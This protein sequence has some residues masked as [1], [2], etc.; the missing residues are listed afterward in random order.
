MNNFV[1]I[2]VCR[3][4]KETTKRNWRTI[5]GIN[6][7]S[8]CKM[9]G[10]CHEN[11]TEVISSTDAAKIVLNA[12]PFVKILIAQSPNDQTHEHVLFGNYCYTVKN[13]KIETILEL[14]AKRATEMVEIHFDEPP[15]AALV[16]QLLNKN[17]ITKI[18]F[19]D[20]DS[21]W[22]QQIPTHGFE[23]LNLTFEMVT[24]DLLSFEGVSINQNLN[25]IKYQYK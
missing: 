18:S 4:W 3:L 5:F 16:K 9:I 13:F 10:T 8:A 20:D 24:E 12:A 21:R 17:K 15:S 7:I 2:S 23:E 1:R 19:D 11:Q 14:L 25:L 6:W 22:Y